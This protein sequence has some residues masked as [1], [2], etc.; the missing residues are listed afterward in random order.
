MDYTSAKEACPVE[1]TTRRDLIRLGVGMFGLTVL[2]VSCSQQQGTATAPAAG[3]AP[4]GV[5]ATPTRAAAATVASASPSSVPAATAPPAG[6]TGV[7]IQ[8]STRGGTDGQIMIKTAEEFSKRTGI[9]VIH[10]AYGPE[11]EY[12]SKVEAL[13][14]TK[15]VADV[16]WASTGNQLNFANRG[17][18]MDLDPIIKADNYDLSDYLPN[19][20]KSLSLKGKLYGMPWGAHPGNGGLVYN[21]KML[22]DAGFTKVTDDPA[23]I[24]DWTYDTLMEAAQKTTKR[25]GDHVDV[26]GYLPGTDYLSLTNVTGAFG[27]DFLNEDGTKLTMDTPEF[28]RGMQWVYDAFVTNKVAP[29]PGSNGDQ[30]FDSQKL[31]M[32]QSGYWGQFQPGI[33]ENAFAWNDSL[34]PM[35]PTG[36]RGTHLTIN[37]Q[38]MSSITQHPKEAW[39][40][41]KFLMSPEQNIQIVLSGGGRPAA[42][43][44]V[45]ESPVLM[46]KMKAHKVWVKA[47]E[48][49]EPWRQPANFRWPEFNTTITQ[50]FANCWI[51]KQ[52]IEQ[53]LPEAKRLL[54]AVLDKPAAK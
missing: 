27:G 17:M 10:V 16:I 4:S 37:G 32:E 50:A 53:A 28:L 30:L 46:E 22:N 14:A 20:L 7:Q 39:E 13:Y 47:I 51:G 45:L 6:A 43:K 5:S 23:S 54:Q 24:L 29:A 26:Y 36:K 3:G 48:S 41:I 19:A 9:K 1:R 31:A 44:A 49:A 42:R 38:C 18:L 15:Q 52:T 34:Q 35:G 2:S 12:W 21:V 40:F 11:P 8:V 33:K 25:T